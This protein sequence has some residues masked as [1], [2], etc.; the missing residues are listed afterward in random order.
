MDLMI[1]AG[2]GLVAGAFLVWLL[3]WPRVSREK[4]RALVAEEKAHGLEQSKQELAK[5]A[6]ALIGEHDVQEERLAALRTQLAEEQ[7]KRVINETSLEEERG[8]AK[9]KARTIE[10]NKQELIALRTQLAEE[11]QKRVGSE[12]AL[13]KEREQTQEK[14]ALLN[15]AKTE[16]TAAFKALSADALAHSNER[17]LQLAEQKLATKHEQVRSELDQ[18]KEAVEQMV[19]PVGESLRRLEEKIQEWDKSSASTLGGLREQMKTLASAEAQLQT[20]AD[21]LVKALRAPQVR[22][23]WG[24]MQLRRLIELAGM[25]NHCDFDEQVTV[26]TE[27]GKLRPDLIIHL[28]N[29][30][31]IVVDSKVPL[32]VYWDA[33]NAQDE[34]A[35]EAKLGA[36]VSNLRGHI[37]QLAVKSYWNQ[38]ESSPDF[39]VM[40][41]P[42]E[43]ALSAAMMKEPAL[44]EEAV[45]ESVILATPATLMA[46]LKAVA[47]G[48]RHEQVAESA[49]QIRDLGQDLFKR[50]SKFVEH[51]S[52][53]GRN[54]EQAVEAFNKAVGSL[55]SRVLPSARR[56]QELGVAVGENAIDAVKPVD[57]TP[58]RITAGSSV[59]EEPSSQAN[60]NG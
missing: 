1:A 28:P 22:G 51:M 7:Q 50:M 29:G 19:K 14:I 58:R 60:E 25:I 9:E 39:V 16:L 6:S 32:D 15:E 37:K 52:G 13:E 33:L 26:A 2:V 11:Q 34:L 43:S 27:E 12:M 17:F 49:R 44:F 3:L 55:E 21:S 40:F 5:Q 31:T 57:T 45:N 23:R 47:Y 30:R 53:I 24:E 38:F 4:T 8:Q 59:P 48:W 46:L 42:L 41:V 20:Q 35:R 54:L 56:F 36:H 18:R 10:E